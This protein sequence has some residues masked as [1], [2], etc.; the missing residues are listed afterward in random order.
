MKITKRQLRRTIRR[1]L[2]EAGMPSSV[3]KHKQR[4]ADMSD[5]ELAEK[6]GW[7]TEEELKTMAWRH[8]YG[9][10]S[11]HYLNRVNRGKQR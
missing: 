5:E 7:K 3:I 11:P 6:H 10:M 9:R 4:L 1:T 2:A 8:G